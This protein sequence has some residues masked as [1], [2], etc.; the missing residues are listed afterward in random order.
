MACNINCCLRYL[1][2]NNF[3]PKYFKIIRNNR[4]GITGSMLKLHEH[5]LQNYAHI[6]ESYIQDNDAKIKLPIKIND[7][8]EDLFD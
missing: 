2:C 5:I 3:E 6:S 8:I 1:W 7:T 4:R